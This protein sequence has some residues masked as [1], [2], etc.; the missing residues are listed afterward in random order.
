MKTG[1]TMSRYLL[2][3]RKVE[4][5]LP[6]EFFSWFCIELWSHYRP[7]TDDRYRVKS[8]GIMC[9]CVYTHTQKQQQARIMQSL[10][11]IG[12]GMATVTLSRKN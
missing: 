1:E 3:W 5:K 2:V 9:V 7:S 10:W 12:P 6:N 8:Q 11:N 4:K